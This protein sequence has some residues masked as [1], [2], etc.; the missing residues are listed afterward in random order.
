[1]RTLVVSGG[2][3]AASARGIATN[4]ASAVQ[5]SALSTRRRVY[6]FTTLRSLFFLRR[7]SPVAPIPAI[8]FLYE[9]TAGTQS[10]GREPRFMPQRRPF[11]ELAHAELACRPLPVGRDAG[12][13]RCSVR[14]LAPSSGRSTLGTPPV[15]C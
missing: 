5:D 8:V 3:S 6:R 7:I 4:G 10:C 13:A 2:G 9:P 11:S 12:R 14:S 15:T 1:M